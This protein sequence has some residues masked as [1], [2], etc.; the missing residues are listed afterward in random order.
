MPPNEQS[1]GLATRGPRTTAGGSIVT[2]R[3]QVFPA[4]EKDWEICGYAASEIDRA[5][6]PVEWPDELAKEILARWQQRA[7]GEAA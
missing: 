1:P 7:R 2:N 5:L 4:T 6:R 3:S